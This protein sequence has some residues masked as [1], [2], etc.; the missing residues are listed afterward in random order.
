MF[1]KHDKVLKQLLILDALRGEDSTGVAA[2]TKGNPVV[3]VA[4]Q[5]GNPYELFEYRGFTNLIAKTNRVMIGH[6]RFATQGAVNRKNAHPFEF[7][8]LV[9]V[10][11]GTLSSKYKLLD[12]KDFD[13]DSENLYHHIEEKGLQ[14]AINQLGS[15]GNAWAL[16]WWDKVNET[17]NFL[18]NKERTL[19]YARSTDGETLFWASEAWML[20]IVLY[21]NDI[22]HGEITLFPED[23]HH[24]VHV[25]NNGVMGKPELRRV[26]A[27]EEKW[28]VVQGGGKH[29]FR[30]LP[31]TNPPAKKEETTLGKSSGPCCTE[32]LKKKAVK[33]ELLTLVTDTMTGAEF[34]SCFDAN[35]PFLDIRLYVHKDDYFRDFLGEVI[36]GDVSGWMQRGNKGFYKISPHTAK[37]LIEPVGHPNVDLHIYPT[38]KGTFV[39]KK[40]WEDTYAVCGWCSMSLSAEDANRFTSAGECL[41]PGCASDKEITQYVNLI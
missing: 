2:V 24:S 25:S 8:T 26:A 13:V 7:D 38:H 23:I 32:Y 12:N 4:K 9:G 36:T 40:E 5:V 1:A 41:C 29:N 6:N 21:R 33:L 16:V 28:H 31:P 27:P 39:S 34:I 14:D 11:N 10:H 30:S 15:P 20:D 19:Y 22:K 18:R 35:E 37:L 3:N 17:I